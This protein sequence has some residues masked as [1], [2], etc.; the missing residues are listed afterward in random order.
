M[1]DVHRFTLGGTADTTLGAV[2]SPDY[3]HPGLPQTRDRFVRVPGRPGRLEFSGDLSERRIDLP[4]ILIDAS[5][6]AGLQA[7]I[8]TFTQILLDTEGKPQ[9]VSLVFDSESDYTYTVRYCG[10]LPIRRL[11]GDTKGAFTLPLIASDPYAYGAEDTDSYSIT[12]AY[13]TEAIENAG[14]YKTPVEITITNS[15]SDVTG[16]TLICRQLKS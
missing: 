11:I 5:T 4:L 7:A 8:K 16:F 10:S 2:L 3:Q 9:D 14:D 1:S 12:A 13:Q 15:G 6:R